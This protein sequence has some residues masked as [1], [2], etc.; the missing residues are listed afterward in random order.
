MEV[1]SVCLRSVAANSRQ[2]PGGFSRLA[3]L[4]RMW[5]TFLIDER[6]WT[7]RYVVVDTGNWIG[8]KSVLIS[9]RA[10]ARV[11]SPARKIFMA[12]YHA[13]SSAS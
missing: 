13:L 6:T 9:A 7:L 11:D 1:V 4:R 8:G 10:V 5:M 2:K 12:G 3:G